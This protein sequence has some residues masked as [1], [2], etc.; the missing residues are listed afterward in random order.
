MDA[1]PLSK[2]EA[3]RRAIAALGYRAEVADIL[4]YCREHF[5]IGVEELGNDLRDSHSPAKQPTTVGAA[6]ESPVDRPAAS[7]KTRTRDRSGSAE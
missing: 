5:G 1:L 2:P 4:A 7:K 3:V 6:K